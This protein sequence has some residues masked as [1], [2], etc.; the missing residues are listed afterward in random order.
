MSTTVDLQSV[1]TQNNNKTNDTTDPED[2]SAT[3]PI[4]L[5]FLQEAS[6]L[7]APSHRNLGGSTFDPVTSDR[8][9]AHPSNNCLD[10]YPQH[11]WAQTFSYDG[12]ENSG[13]YMI[14]THI[15][16]DLQGSNPWEVMSLI[17]L[18]CEK[19]LHHRGQGESDCTSS[20]FSS[21]YSNSIAYPSPSES[22]ASLRGQGILECS[23]HADV[24]HEDLL[25]FTSRG[26]ESSCDTPPMDCDLGESSSES[27]D[28]F[29]LQLCTTNA[30]M[31]ILTE[32][33]P[34]DGRPLPVDE[35]NSLHPQPAHKASM[36]V[37]LSVA[38]GSEGDMSGSEERSAELGPRSGTS[39]AWPQTHLSLTTDDACGYMA[40][41]PAYE[42]DKVVC[43]GHKYFNAVD[44][45]T[46][47]T[48]VALDVKSNLLLTFDP[49]DNAGTCTSMPKPPVWAVLRNEEL[50]QN[51]S[52]TIGKTP[53]T[54][55]IKYHLDQN[56]KQPSITQQS[57]FTWTRDS[58]STDPQQCITSSKA[59][60]DFHTPA[61][62]QKC[63]SMASVCRANTR[64]KQ[65]HPNR[66]ADATDPDFQG[67]MFRMQGELDHSRGQCR[68]L[69]FSKY[70]IS[71]SHRRKPRRRTRPSQSSL[72]SSSSEEDL[73]LSTSSSKSKECASCCTKKTPM[74][75]DAED[76]TPL[77][78]A[79]GIRYKKYR[80][81]CV[82]CW[83]I[84]RKEGNTHSRCLKCGNSVLQ[85]SALHKHHA[86]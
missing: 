15:G 43:L 36:E 54:E 75:R 49:L 17:N 31:S 58:E 45:L 71:S 55:C 12:E 77:C 13:M 66:S 30:N 82:N 41:Q 62:S 42:S 7:A 46:T 76:G 68:L 4:I 78:N 64:R 23:S 24:Q 86:C 81:R 1:S 80:V 52:Q 19:L 37:K 3:Q 60:E 29:P 73:D 61:G 10:A 40:E 48:T 84:P 51:K 6:K 57:Y 27:L 20:S 74:W 63:T 67:V 83:H 18:Q 72:R 14:T 85:T 50:S 53:V 32:T 39:E 44:L 47:D 65:P 5:Q 79:C 11:S 38:T 35:N 34:Y 16:P 22:D 8:K 21:T 69:V 9:D 59:A 26:G 28:K 33:Q 2:Q 56:A 70:R 25:F